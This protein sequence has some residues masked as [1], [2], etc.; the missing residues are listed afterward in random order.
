VFVLSGELLSLQE[1]QVVDVTGGVDI[2]IQLATWKSCL[3]GTVG[4]I[5]RKST[6]TR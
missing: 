1:D 5:I 2:L 4:A 3:A 6:T